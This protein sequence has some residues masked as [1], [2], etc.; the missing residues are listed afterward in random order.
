[1]RGPLIFFLRGMKGGLAYLLQG[2]TC[3]HGISSVI[4]H[5]ERGFVENTLSLV[6]R[7]MGSQHRICHSKSA[8]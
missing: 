8:T 7:T 1:M 3:A 6:K 4:D 5:S 2:I